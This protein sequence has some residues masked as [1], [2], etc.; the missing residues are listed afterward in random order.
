MRLKFV[1]CGVTTL[2]PGLLLTGCGM[3]QMSS[4]TPNV[5]SPAV[6]GRSFGGQ[7]PLVGATISVA[8]MGTSGYGSNGIILAS[9][10]TDQNG[11]FSFAPGAYTCPQSDTPVYLLGIGGN[12]GSGNNGSVVQAAALGTCANAKNSF[13][14]MNEVTTAATA[15]VLSHFFSTTLGG[16]NG[17]NDW[18]GG[19]STSSGGTTVYSQGLAMGSEVT[20]PTIVSM[21]SGQANQTQNGYTVEWQKI[22]TIANI[23]ATC[24]NSSGSTSSTE[25]HTPCGKL[26]NWTSNGA[27]TRPSD[28]L[29]AAV[30]MAL[31]P[32]TQVNNLY[33]SISGKAP[34]TPELA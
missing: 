29:Q 14:V 6:S 10:I 18:F 30:Q 31:F 19:P 22:N 27:A 28:T 5:V 23:L 26:F 15:F 33:N 9:T 32:T 4:V 34:F 21:A 3:N 12:A 25:T 24:V 2:I 13:V 1:L 20:L 7:Q 17:A 8:E 11:N 16:V